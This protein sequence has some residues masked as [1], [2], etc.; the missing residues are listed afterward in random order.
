MIKALKVAAVLI[1]LPIAGQTQS[2]DPTPCLSVCQSI[3]YSEI[4][5]CISNFQ[6]GGSTSAYYACQYAAEGK[7]ST[8]QA[9][10][11]VPFPAKF[12]QNEL[13][14]LLKKQEYNA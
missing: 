14:I 9:R 1:L 6:G 10:C 7:R 5:R 12:K 8:C 4:S 13:M 3:Y 2:Y 11:Y